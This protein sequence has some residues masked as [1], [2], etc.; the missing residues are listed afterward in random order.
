MTEYRIIQ[1]VIPSQGIIKPRFIVDHCKLMACLFVESP[2]VREILHFLHE[3]LDECDDHEPLCLP[4]SL[5]LYTF[6]ILI[7]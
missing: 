6:T 5:E 3:L 4:D 2:Y 7:A 1:Q